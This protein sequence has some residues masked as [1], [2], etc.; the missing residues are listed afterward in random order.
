MIM[1]ERT[2]ELVKT[3]VVSLITQTMTE[4][5]RKVIHERHIKKIHFIPIRYRVLGGLLQSL[6]IKFGN[7]IEILIQLIV[8]NEPDLELLPEI[9]GKKNVKL[10]IN[11]ET[12]ALI[13]KYITESQ[14]AGERDLDHRF[15]DLLTQIIASENDKKTGIVKIHDVDI[16]FR[17]K[18]DGK[19][20]YLEIKYNDDHDTGKFMDINRKFIKTYA[21]IVNK[22]EIRKVD[23]L[24]PILYYLN[25]KKKI[26]NIYIPEDTNIYRGPKLFKEF[27]SVEY[28]ELDKYL[29]EIGEDPDILKIFDDIYKQIRF[30]E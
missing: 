3:A 26:G 19:L 22:L 6:N 16:L 10:A 24:K 20:Y 29:Q 12:D 11:G 8:Q 1:N 27:F 17:N 28:I 5:N 13:D 14:S 4:D 21:G 18:K 9:S 25:D 7:Y 2:K 23:E 15:Q 30:T